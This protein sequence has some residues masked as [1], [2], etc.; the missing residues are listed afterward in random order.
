MGRFALILLAVLMAGTPV[1]ATAQPVDQPQ[2]SYTRLLNR[3]YLRLK[4]RSPTIEEYEAVI[5]ADSDESRE[6]MMTQAVDDALD[7]P[8]FYEEVLNFGY[9]YLDVGRY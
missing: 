1:T 3:I 7:S 6:A 9:E 2:L 8:E 5:N 4:G